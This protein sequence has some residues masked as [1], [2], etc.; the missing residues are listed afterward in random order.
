M[1][2]NK[3]TAVLEKMLDFMA[4]R[5]L[6]SVLF[7]M[8]QLMEV[9]G[10]SEEVVVMEMTHYLERYQPDV[11]VHEII[12]PVYTLTRGASTQAAIV[13][14]IEGGQVKESNLTLIDLLRDQ[15]ESK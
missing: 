7:S 14:T 3:T 6:N 1:V 15:E 10:I 11:R 4:Y 13:V 2:R 9:A 12:P 5:G 8:Q